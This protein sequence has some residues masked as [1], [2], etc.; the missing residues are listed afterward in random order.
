MAID[1]NAVAG[2]FLHRLQAGASALCVG[3]Q[4]GV[5][6]SKRQA[7]EETVRLL[8]AARAFYVDFFLAHPAKLRELV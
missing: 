7:L 5:N 2:R 1:I 6:T 8:T 3:D 4:G